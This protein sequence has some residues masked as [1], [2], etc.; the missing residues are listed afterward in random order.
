MHETAPRSREGIAL[1]CAQR[2]PA[3]PATSAAQRWRVRRPGYRGRERRVAV[4][5][6]SGPTGHGSAIR[7]ARLGMRLRPGTTVTRGRVGK[8]KLEIVHATA[9]VVGRGQ[10]PLVGSCRRKPCFGALSAWSLCMLPA[11]PHTHLGRAHHTS[12]NTLHQR[13]DP[14]QLPLRGCGPVRPPCTGG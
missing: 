7:R 10:Q 12:G 3:M 2:T 1:D 9:S 13:L 8:R 4:L 6:A 11:H 5:P 14:A